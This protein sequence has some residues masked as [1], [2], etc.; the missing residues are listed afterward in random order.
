MY[1]N[2]VNVLSVAKC[3]YEP[4]HH[5]PRHKHDFFHLLYIADGSGCIYMDDSKFDLEPKHIVICP[6]ETGHEIFSFKPALKTIEI[7]F[8]IHDEK[9]MTDVIGKSGCMDARQEELWDILEKTLCEASNVKHMYRD[10][11]NANTFVLLLKLIRNDTGDD[12]HGGEM[13]IVKPEDGN[14]YNGIDLGRIFH[15]IERDLSSL[16]TLDKLSDLIGLNPAYLC[17]IF[18]EKYGVSPIRYINSLRI[19]KAK[20]LLMYS[21]MSITE[22]SE[23]TG[24][25]TIHYFSRCFKAKEKMSPSEYKKNA[26]SNVYVY[27]DE[28]SR[29]GRPC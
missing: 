21:D 10:M 13:I 5:I 6:P 27:L 3:R 23:K 28:K 8:L 1:T 26:N 17:R 14:V 19:K 4:G 25:Q 12:G 2:L 18:R 16:I 7:K 9:L 29:E 11:I 24:F 22:V 15:H 20:E